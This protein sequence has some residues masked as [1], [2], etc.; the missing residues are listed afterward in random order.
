MALSALVF[1]GMPWSPFCCFFRN[2]VWSPPKR[3]EAARSG[4]GKSRIALVG[5]GR[6]EGARDHRR[7]C[8]GPTTGA[9]DLNRS[10]LAPRRIK[11]YFSPVILRLVPAALWLFGMAWR[12]GKLRAHFFPHLFGCPPCFKWGCWAAGAPLQTEEGVWG[13]KSRWSIPCTPQKRFAPQPKPST[14][15]GRL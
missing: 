10:L 3:G 6:E 15:L 11:I 13:T 8:A 7:G 9:A 12:E 14:S 1:L 5:F 4:L 2:S